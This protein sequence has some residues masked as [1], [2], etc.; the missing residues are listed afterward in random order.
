M[1]EKYLT[2]TQLAGK[3]GVSRQAVHKMIREGRVRYE[4]I[5]KQYFIP[6]DAV[7]KKALKSRETA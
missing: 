6:K 7:V 4:R 1:L 3:L 2:P 5:G